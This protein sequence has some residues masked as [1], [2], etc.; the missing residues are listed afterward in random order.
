MPT[1]AKELVDRNAAGKDAQVNFKGIMVGNPATTFYSAIGAGLDTYWGHQL[2]SKPLWEGYKENC[3]NI[4]DIE[5]CEY[6]FLAIYKAVGD[7]NPYALDYPV[8]TE[9]SSTNKGL[10]H[11]YGRSQR[12]WFMNH[13]LNVLTADENGKLSD[14]RAQTLSSL[15]KALG[16]EPVD[17]YEPCEEDYM[18]RYLNRADVK[19]ALH[20]K[21]DIDWVDCSRTLHYKQSDGK[22]DMT[23]YYNYLIDGGFKLNIVVFS[24]DDD[25]VCATIGTQSWIWDLGYQVSG[26]PWQT[27]TVNGQTAGYITK[28]SNT[29]LA[30]VTVHGAGHEV[31]TYKPDVALY[32]FDS[33]LKGELTNA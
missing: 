17:G 1:L 3:K 10:A 31:P 20:V 18:T 32:L 33:Y 14:A 23:P 16:L 26:K 8:C 22:N 19:T 12:V 15:Q 9:D 30:F 27:Y 21:A 13:M 24:G 6:Y 5:A 2:I 29:K 28:W 7:L 25:D 11:K 4:L